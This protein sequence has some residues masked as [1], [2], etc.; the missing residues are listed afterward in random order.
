[1]KVDTES[2]QKYHSGSPEEEEEK[3]FPSKPKRSWIRSWDPEVREADLQVQK[4]AALR[5]TDTI[6][7]MVME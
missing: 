1:M 4:G 3:A 7:C 5:E 2:H 6:H